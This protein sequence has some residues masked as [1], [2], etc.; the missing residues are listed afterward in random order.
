MKRYDF[1]HFPSF[2][3]FHRPDIHFHF[4]KIRIT[5]CHIQNKI[6]KRHDDFFFFVRGD[7]GWIQNFQFMWVSFFAGWCIYKNMNWTGGMSDK[8]VYILYQ[9]VDLFFF[10]FFGYME[11]NKIFRE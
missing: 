4:N 6:S 8:Y 2:S 1:S 5:K 7:T 3:T 11:K 10:L 9:I